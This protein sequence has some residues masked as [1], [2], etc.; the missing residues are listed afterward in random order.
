MRRRAR[1]IPAALAFALIASAAGAQQRRTGGPGGGGVEL[2]RIPA[3]PKHPF[4][5]A[6][7]GRMT[8][9]T[10]EPVP[11]AMIL[12]F[13]D[14]KYTGSTVWPNGGRA[15]H[16]KTATSGETITWQQTNSGGGL[17]Y[18]SLTLVPGD[19]LTGSMELRDAPNFPPPN[20]K[21]K[22]VLIRNPG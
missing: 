1:V 20:P 11:I 14:G 12:E 9:N 3:D 10:D 6:W 13:T 19:M 17:W 16:N 7:V 21:A 15:P 18:Y 8:M 22:F 2:P 5:G 4:S